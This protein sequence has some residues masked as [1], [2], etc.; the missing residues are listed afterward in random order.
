MRLL[1]TLQSRESLICINK[2]RTYISEASVGNPLI[3]V[4][5]TV[6][7]KSPLIIPTVISHVLFM[8]AVFVVVRLLQNS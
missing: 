1:K 6:L 5:L 2:P 7:I 4:L 3:V 8:L